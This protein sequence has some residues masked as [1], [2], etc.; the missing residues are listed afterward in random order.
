LLTE[1]NLRK[2]VDD[3][4]QRVGLLDFRPEKKGSFGRAMVVKWN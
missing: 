2:I 3:G 4:L 1:K